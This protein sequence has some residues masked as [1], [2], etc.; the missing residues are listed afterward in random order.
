[1]RRGDTR[2]EQIEQVWWDQAHSRR[3]VCV[4][5]LSWGIPYSETTET[6]FF[7]FVFHS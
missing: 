1:M 6:C 4:Q 7:L 5:L 2:G 3:D